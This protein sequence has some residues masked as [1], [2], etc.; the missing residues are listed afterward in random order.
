MTLPH[1]PMPG[2]STED[3]RSLRLPP[4]IETVLGR[5]PRTDRRTGA[6]PYIQ[7]VSRTS[8]SDP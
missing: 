7:E 8:G 6:E 3:D 2:T 5:L 4:F 1:E